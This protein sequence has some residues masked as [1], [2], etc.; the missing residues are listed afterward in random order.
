MKVQLLL[1]AAVSHL[2]IALVL[3]LGS[4]FF[5]QINVVFLIV[6]SKLGKVTLNGK[7]WRRM[8]MAGTFCRWLI[9]S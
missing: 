2:V 9:S 5:A 6:C 1:F 8:A 7:Y 4:A 3:L